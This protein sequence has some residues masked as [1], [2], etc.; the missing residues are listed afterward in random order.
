MAMIFPATVAALA[1]LT[2]IPNGS[3]NFVVDATIAD[4]QVRV[5]VKEHHADLLREA[6][7]KNSDAKITIVM[8]KK[9]P[10][11]MDIA[12]MSADIR[13]ADKD[14]TLAKRAENP[15]DTAL[16]EYNFATKMLRRAK[17]DV[18]TQDD[19]PADWVERHERNL[20]QK[21]AELHSAFQIS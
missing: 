4:R 17:A 16:Y 12:G 21:E 8:R 3:N 11:L 1:T 6:L 9:T 13:K 2:A 15:L 19:V 20:K 5:L 18:L 10:V 14:F 7:A